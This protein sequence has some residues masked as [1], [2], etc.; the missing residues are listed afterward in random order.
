MSDIG[1]SFLNLGSIVFMYF[2]HNC[3]SCEWNKV[4][5]ERQT[6]KVIIDFSGFGRF[7]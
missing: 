2:L 6:R 3:H 7:C 5:S 1:V 4:A